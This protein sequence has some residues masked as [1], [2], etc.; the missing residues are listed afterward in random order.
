M[1]V[2]LSRR[3]MLGVTVALALVGG[4]TVF[5]QNGDPRIQKA[6]DAGKVT[7][8]TSV[9]PPEL[10]NALLKGFKNKTGLDVNIYY[11][12]TGTVYSR[13]TTERKT[14][15]F[16]VDVVTLGDVGLVKEL[17]TR[18]VIR[19]Y[20]PGNIDAIQDQYKDKAGYWTG[21]CFWGLI[22]GTNTMH[23]KA[24][25]GPKDWAELA[26]PKWKGKVVILDPARSAGGL[27][28]LKAMVKG[29]GW[30]WVEQLLRNDPLV[31]AVGP[32]IDQA[33]ANG[34]R[35]VS[36]SIT[37]FLSE[38]MKAGAPV[39]PIGDLLYTSP[40]TASVLNNAPNPAGAE[41]F[42]DYLTSKQ[43]GELFRKYG[44]FSSRGDVDGPFGFPPASK[45][46]VKYSDVSLPL[47]RQQI[48][49]KYNQ[50]VLASKR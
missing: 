49:D 2:Q 11:G 35:I 14:G 30:P 19:Q 42:V 7:W 21:I 13:L 24:A 3:Q 47:T 48:L 36:T 6:R 8:Y 25:E 32:G 18:K 26:D 40:L 50:V 5:A 15:S 9:A 38:A 39:K 44:W 34:E 43:A 27:L 12:G 23:L 1:K 29:Q 10:R 41:L 31:I 28:F 46:Q 16:N 17:I 33:L 45:L 4:H 37:S 22:K 20:R